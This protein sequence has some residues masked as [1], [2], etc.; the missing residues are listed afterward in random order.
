MNFLYPAFLLGGLA[1]AIPIVLHFLRRDVAPPVPFTAVRLLQ[2]SPVA[3]SRRR[4]LR[5][6]LLLA[7]RV[8]ALAAAGRRVCASV[9]R[10]RAARTD[11]THC[12]GRSLVQHECARVDLRRRSSWP[13]RAI[14]DASAGE[15]VAVVAFDDHADTIAPPGTA[16]AARAALAGDYPG[17][18]ATRYGE[19]FSQGGGDCRRRRGPARSWSRDLQRSGWEGDDRSALPAGISLEVRDA[20]ASRHRICR[21]CRVGSYGRSGHCCTSAIPGRR[22]RTGQIRIE[23]DGRIAQTATYSVGARLVRRHRDSLSCAGNGFD[24]GVGRR[25]GRTPGG[26]LQICRSGRRSRPQTVLLVTSGSN[27]GYFVARALAAIGGRMRERIAVRAIAAQA[28]PQEDLSQHLGDRAVVDQGAGSARSRCHRRIRAGRRRTVD[29]KLAG[30]GIRGC[31]GDLRLEV[32]DDR[33]DRDARVGGPV[34]DRSTTSCVPAVR[35]ARSESRSGALRTRLARQRRGLGRC[36]TV[37][38]R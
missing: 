24:C 8:V 10:R 20:G 17:F 11:A 28:L 27:G 25:F 37:H 36:R 12:R 21:S 34:A 15:R 16:T 26:Q 13:R 1:I 14:D 19:V 35:I 5:D 2:R 6:L 7:A 3:R 30:G 22:R 9:R 32:A 23:Q 38:R 31:V 18:G 4:R 29:C 33:N